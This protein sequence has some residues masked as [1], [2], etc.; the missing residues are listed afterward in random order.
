MVISVVALVMVLWFFSAISQVRLGQKAEGAEILEQTIR[1]AAVT[2]Y[3]TEGIYPPSLE[4]LVDNYGVLIQEDRYQ[5]FYD[6]FA[7]NLM[8]EIS[9][10]E[11]NKP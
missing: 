3:A 9:V 4:Y 6:G 8:P 11:K 2:C 5:V 7:E 1:K 10:V